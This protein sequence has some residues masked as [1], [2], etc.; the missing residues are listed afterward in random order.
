MRKIERTAKGAVVSASASGPV[1]EV[2]CR[3]EHWRRTRRC[4]TAMPEE[5]WAAA[6]K[7]ARMAGLNATARALRLDYYCLKA[8][9]SKASSSSQKAVTFVEV[10]VTAPLTAAAPAV[11]FLVELERPDGGRMRARL[12]SLDS[13]AVVSDSFWRKRS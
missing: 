2:R 4:R 7:V 5:L 6:A 10:P 11:E 12:P 13:L 9:M 1:S 3:I 8:R